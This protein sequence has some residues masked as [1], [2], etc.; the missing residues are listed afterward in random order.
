VKHEDALVRRFAVMAV[1]AALVALAGGARAD[2]YCRTVTG[3]VE[4]F[5]EDYTRFT[6][7]RSREKAIEAE[8]SRWREMRREVVRVERDEPECKAVYPL[9]FEEWSCVAKADICVKR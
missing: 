7:E 8:L 3:E 5:G 2:L 4:G 1:V 6:A 9:G